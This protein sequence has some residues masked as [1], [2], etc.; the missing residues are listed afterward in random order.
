[1]ACTC[2]TH[3]GNC[4]DCNDKW[5]ARIRALETAFAAEREAVRVLGAA[6]D[7]AHAYA[8][9][10]P[11]VIEN[12]ER[13]DRMDLARSQYRIASNAVDSNPIAA[14]ALTKA[15]ESEVLTNPLTEATPQEPQP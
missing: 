5:I 1:M 12:D 13:H 15:R 2:Y 7:A 11:S 14:A 10:V 9:F 3:G 6:L 4:P 8:R